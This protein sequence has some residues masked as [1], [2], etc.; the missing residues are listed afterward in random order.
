MTVATEQQ[1]EE[2]DSVAKLHTWN[3]EH[4]LKLLVYFVEVRVRDVGRTM[5][6]AGGGH[7]TEVTFD[8]VDAEI[9]AVERHREHVSAGS[10]HLLKLVE[11]ELQEGIEWMMGTAHI[12]QM[13]GDAVD[14]DIVVVEE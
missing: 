8:A 6:I 10:S 5:K 3:V 2:I 13:A 1:H 11:M 9:V 4:L 12:A 7:R 14:F